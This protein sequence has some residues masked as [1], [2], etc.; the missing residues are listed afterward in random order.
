M[1]IHPYQ[2]AWEKINDLSETWMSLH[3][4]ADFQLVHHAIRIDCV[5]LQRVQ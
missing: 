2:E 4:F 5:T 3:S 1:F